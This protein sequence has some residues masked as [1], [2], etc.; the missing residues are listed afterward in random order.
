M[1]QDLEEK[2]KIIYDS[3]PDALGPAEFKYKYVN[4]EVLQ[5]IVEH[6]SVQAVH[7]AKMDSLD[8]FKL[9]VDKTFN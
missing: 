3:L 8:E 9:I 2:L 7:Q 4:Y 1:T 6:I 5:T